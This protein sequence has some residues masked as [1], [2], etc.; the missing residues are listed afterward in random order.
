MKEL[1]RIEDFN[2]EHV[3]GIFNK[4][5]CEVSKSEKGYYFKLTIKEQV[6]SSSDYPLD[7]KFA[8]SM[9]EAENFA[10]YLLNKTKE[11]STNLSDLEKEDDLFSGLSGFEK[12]ID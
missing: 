8:L 12:Q 7:L 6:S 10:L 9:E 3:N 11:I 5:E 2:P 4:F 1:I